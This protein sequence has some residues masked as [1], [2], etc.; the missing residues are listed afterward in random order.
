MQESHISIS[1]TKLFKYKTQSHMESVLAS[2]TSGKY[3]DL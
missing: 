1:S 2:R 3:K